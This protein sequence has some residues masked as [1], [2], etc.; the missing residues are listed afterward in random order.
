MP[1]FQKR[2]ACIVESLERS[3]DETSIEV[4]QKR[5]PCI[6]EILLGWTKC[7]TAL[8]RLTMA[9]CVV[10]GWGLSTH[11]QMSSRDLFV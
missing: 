10:G 4:P 3:I 5:F 11:F 8:C 9:K 2:S 7:D 6:V 1:A